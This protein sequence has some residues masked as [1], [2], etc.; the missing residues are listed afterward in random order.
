MGTYNS[1]ENV[2]DDGEKRRAESMTQACVTSVLFHVFLLAAYEHDNGTCT[3][4]RRPHPPPSRC[5][6]LTASLPPFHSQHS[7]DSR[8]ATCNRP[9]SSSQRNGDLP[10]GS[11]RSVIGG[12]DAS[13]RASRRVAA[14][15][16]NAER[17]RAAGA[18]DR[19]RSGA[20][21]REV[22]S[23]SRADSGGR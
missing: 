7:H 8:T 22:G 23:H 1:K 6:S 16:D 21:D 18:L 20:E 13:Q 2:D 5:S 17:L 4:P 19:S 11:A 10:P 15:G 9:R 12:R 3:V 14:A